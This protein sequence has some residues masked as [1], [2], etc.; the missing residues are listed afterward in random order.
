MNTNSQTKITIATWNIEGLLTCNGT[1][2]LEVPSVKR[3]VNKFDIMCLNETWQNTNEHLAFSGYTVFSSFRSR[4]HVN[5]KRNSGGVAVLIRNSIAKGVSKQQSLSDDTIWLKLSKD[6]FGM[7]DHIYLCCC[8]LIPQNSSIF[9]W[10]ELNVCE[11]LETEVRKYESFGKIILCGDL[12]ARTGN[13]IDFVESDEANDTNIPLPTNYEPDVVTS[14]RNNKDTVKNDYGKNLIEM[15]ISGNLSILNGRT[16][17]DYLGNYTCYKTGGLSTVDYN[18]VS[19]SLYKNVLYFKVHTFTEWS[20]HCPIS[21][22]IKTNARVETASSTCNLKSMPSRYKWDSDSSMLFRFSLSTHQEELNLFL[23]ENYTTSETAM[24]K[25]T[26]IINSASRNSIRKVKV[27]KVYRRHKF[28]FTESCTVLRKHLLYTKGLMQKYP[29]NREIRSCFYSIRKTFRKAV[30]Q[31]KQDFKD[32]IL[33]QLSEMKNTDPKA[34]WKLL[35]TLRNNQTKNKENSISPEMW[36]NHFM[37]LLTVSDNSDSDLQRKLQEIQNTFDQFVDLDNPFTEK[38]VVEAIN[39]L[40]NNKSP[41]PDG[42]INEMFKHGKFY[43]LKP[44]TK[45][46]NIVLQTHTVPNEWKKGF[47]TVIYKSGDVNCTG[48]YRGIVVCSCLGKLFSIVMN[49]RLK[50]KLENEHILS[51]HQGGFRNDHR[52]ADNLYI[53]QQLIQHYKQK[54]QK[55]YTCFVDFKK[56]FDTVSRPGL[57]I[58]LL[59]CKIGG[60]FYQTIRDM[61]QNDSIS[62]KIGNKIT[63]PIDCNLG[64]RQGDS[65]S[66]TLFNIFINEITSLFET[67]DSTPAKLGNLYIGSLL[68]ADDLVIFSESEEGLQNSLT[69]LER[70]C[71]NWKLQVNCDKTQILVFN[72]KTDNYGPFYIYDQPLKVVH[73]YK[74]LGILV[75]RSGSFSQA[76]KSLS[77]KSLKA[78]Y[79]MKNALYSAKE[80]SMSL[81]LSSFDTLIKPILLYASEIWG[82][83]LLH[84]KTHILQKFANN[85]SEL[86]RVHM[87]FCKKL[88]GVNQTTTNLAVRS[89]LGRNPMIC[90]VIYNVIK[91]FIR[92]EGMPNNRLVKRAYDQTK[93]KKFSLYN[94]SKHLMTL[95]DINLTTYNLNNRSDRDTLYKLFVSKFDTLVE[96]EWYSLLNSDTGPTGQR[97]KLRLY[98]KLK[99][100]FKQEKYLEIIKNPI[101]RSNLTKLR[102]SA[103]NLAIE[104]G[105]YQKPFGNGASNSDHYKSRV[106]KYCNENKVENEYHFTLECTKYEEQRK[107]FIESLPIEFRNKSSHELFLLLMK[108]NIS[109]LISPFAKFIQNI[110]DERKLATLC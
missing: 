9:S 76:I 38:E 29:H 31:A 43:L 40:K 57:L 78:L 103:H 15:C 105:R 17:G 81:H 70:Y 85:N 42:Y 75:S 10:N 74:Y 79:S 32:N 60:K 65:L 67:G 4:R 108:S 45:L 95:T 54:R 3:F 71:K 47:L 73:S 110:T 18:I 101:I 99:T 88:L 33:K 80:V 19:E 82:Q 90:S 63:N 87:R 35:D 84:N 16:N 100:C 106:C 64:V 97:N 12:N 59:E 96:E 34:Y 89:E 50:H 102:I 98:A 41:G 66:P 55:L 86:E 46:F 39:S 69:K 5:A 109:S 93:N 52:T 6:Y 37:K 24:A 51:D 13:L 56:A 94:I 7:Q 36:V 77:S 25:L 49:N 27:K 11:T 8:Y 107:C 23:Q 28:K 21:M 48:N 22:G 30:K 2:K 26:N 44:I 14:V 68:Y 62:I 58:R 72:S 53:L 104:K 91:F 20:D 83:D 1:N 61:Y 92:L